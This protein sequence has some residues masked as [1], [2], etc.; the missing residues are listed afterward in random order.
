MN[1]R[2]IFL[3]IKMVYMPYSGFTYT[4]IRNSLLINQVIYL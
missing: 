3:E 2:N 1:S 4:V